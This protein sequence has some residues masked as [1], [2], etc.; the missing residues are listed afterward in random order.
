MARI[1]FTKL[2]L[3]ASQPLKTF[4]VVYQSF[5]NK[6][7]EYAFLQADNAIALWAELISKD[8]QMRKKK[9]G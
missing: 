5:E 9:R 1:N 2:L 3:K 6:K 7:A 4:P 8:K